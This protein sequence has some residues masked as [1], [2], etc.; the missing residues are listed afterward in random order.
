MLM[1][2]PFMSHVFEPRHMKISFLHYAK[3]NAQIRTRSCSA[4]LVSLNSQYCTIPPLPKSEIH[5]S[6]VA[7]QPGLCRTWSETPKTGTFVTQLIQCPSLFAILLPNTFQNHWLRTIFGV[8][9][10]L[11]YLLTLISLASHV[12]AELSVKG[13][14]MDTQYR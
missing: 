6:S 12:W 2:V 5:P 1:L 9:N 4:L 11:D 10:S 7:V 14:R 13:E 3:T 8:R